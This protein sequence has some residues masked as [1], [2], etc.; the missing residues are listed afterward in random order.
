MKRIILLLVA[1]SVLQASAQ[2]MGKQFEWAKLIPNEL[3]LSANTPYYDMSVSMDDDAYTREQLDENANY[4][5]NNV[6]VTSMVRKEGKHKFSG[7]GTY[8]FSVTKSVDPNDIYTVNY[9]IDISNKNGR[10]EMTM[11]D[12]TLTHLDLEVSIPKRVEAAERND[13]I[14]KNILASMHKNNLIELKKAYDTMYKGNGHPAAATA[15]K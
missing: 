6:F 13:V 4:Y 11:H 9:I 1:F 15:S 10:F 12:F 8:S 2:N 3:P 14:S 5:F 7:I